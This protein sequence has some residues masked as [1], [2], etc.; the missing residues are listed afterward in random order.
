MVRQCLDDS[1]FD[2]TPL[3][4]QR[5][6]IDNIPNEVI[7]SHKLQGSKGRKTLRYS[8]AHKAS[9]TPELVQLA[10]ELHNHKIL[11][12]LRTFFSREPEGLL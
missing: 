3:I 11:D 1:V 12:E 5:P 10:G 9:D 8:P 2:T 6:M 7:E 4:N